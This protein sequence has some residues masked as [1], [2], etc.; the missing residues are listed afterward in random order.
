MN[1]AKCNKKY[2]VMI[3]GAGPAGLFFAEELSRKFNVLVVE[4]NRVGRSQKMWASWP[5]IIK[6][7]NL[8]DCVEH[9]C[10]YY[11]VGVPHLKFEYK[12]SLGN[13]EMILLLD[14]NK[15]LKKWLNAVRH[16]GA[17]VLEECEFLSFSYLN[18]AIRIKT[19]KG[20]FEGRLLIDASGH[21]S[22]IVKALNLL[23]ERAY[24]LCYGGVI[25]NIQDLDYKSLVITDVLKKDKP[26]PFWI[27]YP[28]SKNCAEMALCFLVRDKSSSLEELN[29]KKFW[30]YTK[31]SNYASKLRNMKFEQEKQSY[32]SAGKLKT[33][34]LDRL[35][36]VGDAGCLAP[37]TTG[38]G[39][40]LIL[41]CY[42]LFTERLKRKLENDNLDAKSLR[43]VLIFPPQIKEVLYLNRL[44]QHF[45]LN[46]NDEQ[47]VR[48]MK[49]FTNHAEIFEELI[50]KIRITKKDAKILVRALRKEFS[51]WE[52]FKALSFKNLLRD[53]F[54]R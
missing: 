27:V 42:D 20:S 31:N 38:T 22:K 15:I 3:I 54:R 34:A 9:R 5:G 4:K 23:K 46:I 50:W 48:L 24:W 14:E 18:R 45:L 12:A 49:V 52:I 1:Q 29:K 51:L 53:I 21:S 7:H 30:E 32:I 39:F 19:T 47:F 41:S 35:L 10:K 2:D 26:R 44:C 13:K 25:S 36:I 43:G 8:D 33:N 11:V 6:K 16:Q 28:I 37:A 40:D 17:T